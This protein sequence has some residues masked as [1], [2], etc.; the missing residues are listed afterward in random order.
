[1][2]LT[3]LAIGQVEQAFTAYRP[4][5]RANKELYNEGVEPTMCVV[6]YIYIYIHIYIYIYTNY[7]CEGACAC[8]CASSDR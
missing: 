3:H 4:D 6:I 7:M 8:V 1:M 2:L 5:G